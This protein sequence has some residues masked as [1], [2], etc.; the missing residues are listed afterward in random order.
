MFP[1]CGY[2][3]AHADLGVYVGDIG[4][5]IEWAL[6]HHDEVIRRIHAAQDFVRWEYAPARIAKLWLEAL[7][8]V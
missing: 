3:P 6:S 1:I 7:A 2:L 5:G 4:D 8:Y